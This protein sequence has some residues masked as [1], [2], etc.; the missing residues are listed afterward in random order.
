MR[1][2][3][4][5]TADGHFV[6]VVDVA[7]FPD[8]GMPKIVTW[9]TRTFRLD[10]QKTQGERWRYD[11]CFAVVSLTP[12]PGRPQDDSASRPKGMTPL[13]IC[14]FCGETSEAVARSSVKTCSA[15]GDTAPHAWRAIRESDGRQNLSAAPVDRSA[16]C[17]VGQAVAPGVPNTEDRGDGQQKGY[18][19][20][21]AEE[22]AKGFVRPVRRTYLHQKCGTTTTMGQSLA[23]TY[24]R[25][26][27]FYSGTFCC[28]CGAHFPVGADGEFTWDGTS[29]KVGT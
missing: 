23:E 27:A 12:S 29:D 18:V 4:L 11:E 7:P 26:P 10:E 9:G 8:R 5:W 6:A 17:T 13:E 19:I 22:R 1:E 3:E 25:D 2:I 24:A 15:R 14:G 21:C 20:L 16:R 28:S